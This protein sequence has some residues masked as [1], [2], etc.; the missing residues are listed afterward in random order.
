MLRQLAL[1]NQQHAIDAQAEVNESVQNAHFLN[2][3][4][5]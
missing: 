5:K 3:N 1:I 4:Y 2:A